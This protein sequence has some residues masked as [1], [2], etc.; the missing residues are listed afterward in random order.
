[1]AMVRPKQK[2][3]LQR[4]VPI[5][6]WFPMYDW[7]GD[8]RPD[9]MAGLTVWA[10]LVPEAMAYA[11]IAGVPPEAGLYA[12]PLA[13]V[14]Y[15]MFGS[16]RHLFVG[17]SSTV[18]ILSATVIAPLA[19]SDGTDFWALTSWLAIVTG[20]LFVIFGLL[21]MGWVANFLASSVL[22][23]FLVGLALVIA[24]GQTD[25]ILGIESEGGN[26]PQELWSMV[27]QFAEWSWP[28]IA[29]GVGS[30]LALFAIERFWSRIPG[31]LVVLFGA[32]ILSSL[33]DFE[34]HG[35]HIVGEIPGGLPP[36]GFPDWIGWQT[37]G[38]LMIGALSIILVGYAE[39][40]AAAKAYAKQFGY[41]IDANQELIGLGMANF[42]AGFSQG[43]VV[44]GSLSKSAAG[45]ASGQKTQMTSIITA[46]LTLLTVVALT[47]L[48][49]TLPEA[50]L[51]AIV[52]HAVWHLIDFD[53]FKVL[54]NTRRE[55]FW[56]ATLAFL[57]VV[58]IDILPGIVIG[59]VLS[60]LVLIYRASFPNGSEM[61]IVRVGDHNFFGDVDEYPDAVKPRPG[62]V[63]RWNEALI[64]SNAS[65]FSATARELLWERTDPPARVLVVD[66][67]EMSDM[68]VTGARELIDFAAELEAADTALWLTHLSGDALTTAQ[69]A[70]VVDAI[71][72][73]SIFPTN[74]DAEDYAWAEL[75]DES[76][77]HDLEAPLPERLTDDGTGSEDD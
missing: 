76:S 26:V 53:K 24:I 22:D 23:G 37:L 52:V 75:D 33:F 1:M 51:G 32:I 34:S 12:A 19:A 54:W 66:C 62:V 74:R 59:I 20:V 69:K 57:G 44:D 60:L 49:R 11:G 4:Y 58:L 47:P 2:S 10:L 73:E 63:F 55:D 21:R 6:E 16:S 27:S 38:S 31:A 9:F 72:L 15:A 13:L 39:S 61:G 28:T 45:V 42:G 48:F 56:L 71:G 5:T 35:I 18:A 68:D 40:W 41:Q 50:T 17:P 25:K 30:L 70:G 43:F 46:G 8:L 3:I 67:S 36:V 14:L 65:A 64:F 77:V 29:V 7:K